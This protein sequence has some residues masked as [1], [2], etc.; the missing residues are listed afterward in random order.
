MKIEGPAAWNDSYRKRIVCVGSGRDLIKQRKIILMKLQILFRIENLQKPL[1]GLGRFIPPPYRS[2]FR[3]S[4]S[5]HL[6][7]QTLWRLLQK[8]AA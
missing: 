8:I 4:S 2:S 1:Q 3:Y 7:H 5:L 6:I